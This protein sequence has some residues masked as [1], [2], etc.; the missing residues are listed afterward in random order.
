[1]ILSRDKVLRNAPHI[2]HSLSSSNPTR[3]A[4]SRRPALGTRRQ[5]RT[6]VTLRNV[7]KRFARLGSQTFFSMCRTQTVRNSRHPST[8]PHFPSMR[9]WVMQECIRV[10]NVTGSTPPVGDIRQNIQVQN[11][12]YHIATLVYSERSGSILFRDWAGGW[13]RRF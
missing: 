12:I 8:W 1:M 10:H 2:S 13:A 3:R 9:S 6:H 11:L 5:L 4:E 7:N